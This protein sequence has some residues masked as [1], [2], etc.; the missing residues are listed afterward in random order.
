MVR[1]GATVVR[2]GA[3]AVRGGAASPCISFCRQA[4][5]PH[6]AIPPCGPMVQSLG[7]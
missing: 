4:L 2:G 1:G 3:T 6:T 5:Q 7:E